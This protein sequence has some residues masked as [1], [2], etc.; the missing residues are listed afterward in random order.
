[1]DNK[2]ILIVDDESD[3]CEILQVNLMAEGYEVDVAYSA[4][5]AMKK[6]LNLYKLILLDVMMPGMSG[7]Q[8]ARLLR[9]QGNAT[10]IIFLTAR[11][12]EEDKLQGFSLGADDYISKPFSVRE[13]TAR[14]KAV[15]S[16][17]EK[18]MVKNDT[19]LSLGSL[20]TF[21]GL[22][23]NLSQ[24]SASADGEPL[25][26]TKTELNL[27]ILLLKHRGQVFSRQQLL[28]EVWPKDVVVT[29]RTVD[30]NI[31]RLRKKLRHYGQYII[32]RQGYGYLFRWGE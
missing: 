7:F 17:S 21:N 3:L 16:R 6:D 2:P 15:L 20:L 4:D 1:M 11:D 29:E 28:D 30:V 8:M 22:T 26:L 18:A 23:I 14:V 5:E 12:S 24:M 32:T 31:T 27:L 10:P 13:L 9:V 25:N 19:T